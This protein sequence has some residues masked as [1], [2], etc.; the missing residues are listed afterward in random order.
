MAATDWSIIAP[1][2]VGGSVVRFAELLLDNASTFIH[3]ILVTDGSHSHPWLDDRCREAILRKRLARG[4][5]EFLSLRDSC[6]R[7]LMES[8]EK[9]VRKTRRK[10]KSMGG[11]SRGWW[12]VSKSL[13][14]VASWRDPIPPLLRG[15][16]T[17]AKSPKEKADLFANVF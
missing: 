11:S 6:S 4:T 8:Y 1:H 12:K 14:Q 3:K 17:W 16:G 13:M 2:D 10:L 15:D 7:I 5:P 9:Y